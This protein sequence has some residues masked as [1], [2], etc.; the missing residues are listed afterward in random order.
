VCRRPVESTTVRA[1][2]LKS[3]RRRDPQC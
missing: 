3:T 1:A 2:E